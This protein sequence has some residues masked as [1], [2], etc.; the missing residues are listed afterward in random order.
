MKNL[1]LSVVI[2]TL[3]EERNIGRCLKSLRFS[4]KVFSK[5]EIIV[6][7][8]LSQDLTLSIARKLGAKVYTRPWKGYAD[9]K[10]WALAKCGGDWILSLDADEELRPELIR[11]VDRKDPDAPQGI[12]G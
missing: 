9:Q 7:D 6:V 8:A 1:S 3:N 10:N 4:G 11:R 2:I 5:P 12:D